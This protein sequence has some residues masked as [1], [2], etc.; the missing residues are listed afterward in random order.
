MIGNPHTVVYNPVIWTLIHEL[1]ISILFPFIVLLVKKLNTIYVLILCAALSLIAGL[2][3][4]LSTITVNG[5]HT[6][7][8]DSLHYISIFM[9]GA[10]VAKNKTVLSTLYQRFTKMQKISF[11]IM[12]VLLYSYSDVLSKDFFHIIPFR[13]YVSEYGLSLGSVLLIIM[14]LASRKISGLLNLPLLIFLGKI[15]YSLYLTHMLVILSLLHLL[16]D[17]ISMPLLLTLSGLVSILTA[18]I[19]WYFVELPSMKLGKY[20]TKSRKNSVPSL[21]VRQEA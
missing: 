4:I 1:R 9:I 17:R 14:A 7:L 18:I 13:F 21:E 8:F 19:C 11:L 2:A 16:H 6:S 20:L 12:A 5:Y 10:L 15:S 3:G